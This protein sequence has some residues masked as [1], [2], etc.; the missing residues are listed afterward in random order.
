MA[1]FG[2]GGAGGG[3]QAAADHLTRKYKY[4]QAGETGYKLIFGLDGDRDQLAF[5]MKAG[6]ESAGD[7]IEMTS[8]VGEFSALSGSMPALLRECNEKIIGALVASGDVVLLKHTMPVTAFTPESFDWALRV[9]TL[10]A[11]QLEKKFTGGNK[12]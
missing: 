10:T 12:F 3:W 8:P 11:D 5:V 1:F 9:L 6:N 2:S 7:W 4:Q